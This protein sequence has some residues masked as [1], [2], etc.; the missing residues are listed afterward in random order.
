MYIHCKK[1]F[2]EADRW[3]GDMPNEPTHASILAELAKSEQEIVVCRSRRMDT[4]WTLC[5]KLPR[6]NA[7]GILPRIE[8]LASPPGWDY[9]YR[10]YLLKAEWGAVLT[11]IAMDLDYRNFKS[12]AARSAPQE[13]RLAHDIWHAASHVAEPVKLKGTFFDRLKV[14]YDKDKR[15]APP[16]LRSGWRIPK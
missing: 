10:V 5:S 2:V 14:E 16:P 3:D 9:Q 8:V 12:Y 7:K 11:Q 15:E 13:N 6:F 1:G 4:L